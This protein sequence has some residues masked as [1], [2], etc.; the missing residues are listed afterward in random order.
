M[1][2]DRSATHAEDTIVVRTAMRLQH[3]GVKTK[4][5][6]TDGSGPLRPNLNPALIKAV[7]RAHVWFQRLSAESTLTAAAIAR[8]YKVSG[9]YVRQILRLTF[10]APDIVEAI[11]AGR[12]PPELQLH[13]MVR[14]LPMAWPDQ[15]RMYGF[16]SP[17]RDERM[18]AI[19][20]RSVGDVT[21]DVSPP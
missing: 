15:R 20:A 5:I 21:A 3:A 19:K 11:L 10:L 7:A 16:P 13:R 8:E 6:I 18:P 17:V 12:Q 2:P 9:R 1:T 14:R 4:L